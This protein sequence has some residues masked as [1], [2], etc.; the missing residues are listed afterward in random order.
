MRETIQGNRPASEME[1]EEE[2]KR[3][4]TVQR[5]IRKT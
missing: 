3:A 4:V 1:E 2:S 5:K